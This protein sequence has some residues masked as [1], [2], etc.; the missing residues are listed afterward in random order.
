[1]APLVEHPVPVTKHLYTALFPPREVVVGGTD[2]QPEP[3]IPEPLPIVHSE[4][5]LLGFLFTGPG[6]RPEAAA[7]SMGPQLLLFWGLL[8]RNSHPHCDRERH[9]DAQAASRAQR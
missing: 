1:M 8:Q 5:Q 2:A 3:F 7:R 9:T 6:P 4:Q